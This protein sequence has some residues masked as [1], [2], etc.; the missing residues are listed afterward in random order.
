MNDSTDPYSERVLAYFATP[1]HAGELQ[2]RYSRSVTGTA[3]ESS[4]GCR[5]TLVAGIADGVFREVRFR[6]FGCPH[7][8]AAAEECCR[9]LEGQRTGTAAVPGLAELMSLLRVP[10]EKTGRML[11]L[12]DAWRELLQLLEQEPN[13]MN[14]DQAGNC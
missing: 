8:I 5:V 11:L 6:V 2:T 9:R 12:E 7:L 1:A 4:A 13:T 10:V 14:Q 3:A